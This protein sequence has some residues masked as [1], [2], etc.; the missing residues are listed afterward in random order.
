MRFYR[1]RHCGNIIAYAHY[2][3]VDVVCCGEEMQEI[4]PGSTDGAKEKHVPV[5]TVEGNKVTV[6]VGSVD[7][8]MIDAHYIMWIAL[9]TKYGNQRHELK[10]GD[11]P[12][13]T[14]IINDG[15]EVI[16]AYEYCNLHSLYKGTL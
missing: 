7:H 15:D 16:A 1:C 13:A 10:P 5:I 14:F 12:E 4:I 8:P 11:A 6:K 2:S 3:G 9:E